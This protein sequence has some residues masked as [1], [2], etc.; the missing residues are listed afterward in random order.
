MNVAGRPGDAWWPATLRA[1]ALVLRPLTRRDETAWDEVRRQNWAWLRQWDATRPPEA[2]PNRS[3][4]ATMLRSQRDFARAGRSLP[5]ALAWDDGWPARPNR[6]TRLIGQVS[7]SGIAFGSSRSAYIGYW[8]D[9]QW[10]GRGLMPLGV[11][12]ASDYC[13]RVLRLHRLEIDILPENTRSHRVVEKLGFTADG[14]HRSLLHING[15][16]REHDAF[17]MTADETPPSL[18]AHV[19]DGRPVPSNG[20]TL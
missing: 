3:T 19:L 16:W 1:G 4:F 11:A 12:L 9:Q 17:I 18:L 20:V 15:V 14:Q 2:P 7:V 8:I 13:F 5:W 6:R 10:A